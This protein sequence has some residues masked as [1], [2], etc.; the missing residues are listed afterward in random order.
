MYVRAGRLGAELRVRDAAARAVPVERERVDAD[1]DG[2]GPE[3]AGGAGQQLL[4]AAA[5]EPGP[6]LL[7]QPAAG[8]LHAQRVR[9]QLRG[10]RDALEGEVRLRHDQDGQH[11]G[12]HGE[13]GPDQAQLQRRQQW[14]VVVGGGAEDR[15]DGALLWIHRVPRGDRHQLIG[16]MVLM[17]Y[18]FVRTLSIV[19]RL[20]VCVSTYLLV[21]YTAI[22]EYA[23]ACVHETSL[24]CHHVSHA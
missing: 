11:R 19:F 12:A 14:L 13:P 8:Q 20:C 5:A 22:Y 4:Q 15:D 10:Q 18:V 3:H 16:N 23:S 2:A 24:L 7:R 17:M 1:D 21:R 6:L 9:E